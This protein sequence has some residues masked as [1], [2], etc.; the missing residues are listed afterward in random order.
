[1]ILAGQRP[2]SRCSTAPDAPVAVAWLA[3]RPVLLDVYA[4]RG[5]QRVTF[6]LPTSHLSVRHCVTWKRGIGVGGGLAG[7][8]TIANNYDQGRVA[9]GS[10]TVGGSGVDCPA[11]AP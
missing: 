11:W 8:V 1:M 2:S 6:G 10:R 7:P 4:D 5:V 3:P 9:N